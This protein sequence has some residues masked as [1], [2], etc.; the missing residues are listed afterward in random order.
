MFSDNY[1]EYLKGSAEFDKYQL[2]VSKSFIG[3]GLLTS[4]Y[5][6][7]QGIIP[8]MRNDSAKKGL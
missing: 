6:L 1:N 2:L 5:V 8:Y 3:I 4:L 7:T